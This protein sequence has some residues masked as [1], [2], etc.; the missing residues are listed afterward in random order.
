MAGNDV[1]HFLRGTSTIRE[2]KSD[3]LGKGQPFYETDTNKLYIGDD[4]KAI[5]NL[6][7][8]GNNIRTYWENIEN[9]HVTVGDRSFIE[10]NDGTILPALCVDT[11]YNSNDNYVNTT[12]WQVSYPYN[13]TALSASQEMANAA[14]EQTNLYK[15]LNTGYN[16]VIN[17]FPKYLKDKIIPVTKSAGVTRIYITSTR[18]YQDIANDGGVSCQLWTPAVEEIFG[19][20]DGSYAF[21]PIKK[22]NDFD[23]NI[24]QFTYYQLLLKNPSPTIDHLELLSNR[25]CWLRNG[26]IRESVGY[27]Q[28]WSIL[29]G[30]GKVDTQAARILNYY[31]YNIIFCFVV[32]R[33]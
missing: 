17:K 4:I 32:G 8:V 20:L 12:T 18:T 22:Y 28:D 30:S 3:I 13:T 23:P 21:N 24:K 19:P 6:K 33:Q 7:P 1:I 29:K 31:T 2:A 10:L 15:T 9:I 5:N 11:T 25:T 26:G 16:A 27:V 14:Y